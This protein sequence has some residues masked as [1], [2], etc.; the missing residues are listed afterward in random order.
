MIS[1]APWHRTGGD[2]PTILIPSEALQNHQPILCYPTP[3]NPIRAT[4]I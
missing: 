3:R 1:R 2:P 4:L